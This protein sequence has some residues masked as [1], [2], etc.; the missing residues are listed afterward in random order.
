[1]REDE[2]RD[3]LR[4]M[5]DDPVPADSLVRVRTR[6]EERIAGRGRSRW[7][8]L[9]AAV[10]FAAICLIA[11]VTRRDPQPLSPPPPPL[12]AAVPAPPPAQAH[13]V[14]KPRHRTRKP[15]TV[16]SNLL[17][18]IETPDPDVVILLLGD[19]SGT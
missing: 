10:A 3:L 12:I 11:V 2:M 14:A 19:E 1:M 6:V 17:I 16:Q 9:L 5:R 18:R 15:A 7:A 4:E 13:V 8:A